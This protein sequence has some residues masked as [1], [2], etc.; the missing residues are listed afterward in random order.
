MIVLP[1]VDSARD[2]DTLLTLVAAA[3]QQNDSVSCSDVIHAV[4]RPGVN[5][6]FPNAFAQRL[7]ITKIAKRKP[8]DAPENLDA[9]LSILKLI[10]MPQ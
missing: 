1:V 5:S 2:V 10:R 7:A 9:R 4:P 3:Q 6:Q 8:I